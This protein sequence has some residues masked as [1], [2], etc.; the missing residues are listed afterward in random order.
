MDARRLQPQDEAVVRAHHG[1]V[2]AFLGRAGGVQG[3]DCP[4]TE[5]R[6]P[7]M[8][9]TGEPSEHST[10]RQGSRCGSGGTTSHG[11]RRCLPPAA[12]STAA[13]RATA[14]M[15]GSTSRCRWLGRLSERFCAGHTR[16]A[17]GD[18]RGFRSAVGRTDR[19]QQRLNLSRGGFRIDSRTHGPSAGRSHR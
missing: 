10:L 5:E 7:P 14:S 13:P 4:T 9:T 1:I 19:M 18:S 16:S 3:G 6:P 17:R 2:S 11:W 15:G 12:T 8:R